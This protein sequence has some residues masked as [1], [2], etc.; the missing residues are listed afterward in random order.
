MTEPRCAFEHNLAMSTDGEPFHDIGTLH[1]KRTKREHEVCLCQAD[2]ERQIAKYGKW[3]RSG[4]C[5]CNGPIRH[6]FQP[7]EKA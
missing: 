7:E 1:C 4:P 2:M 5:A 3:S 6:P